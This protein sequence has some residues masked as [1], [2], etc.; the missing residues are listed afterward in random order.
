MYSSCSINWSNLL[1][2]NGSWKGLKEISWKRLKDVKVGSKRNKLTAKCLSKSKSLN[3]LRTSRSLT[4]FNWSLRAHWSVSQ[5]RRSLSHRGRERRC[6]SN[7][8][9][10]NTTTLARKETTSSSTDQTTI[11]QSKC[12]TLKMLNNSTTSH[13]STKVCRKRQSKPCQSRA[14]SILISKISTS[15]KGTQNV[16]KALRA[17]P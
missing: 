13:Q 8:W 1:P 11:I 6:R 9:I 16:K 2:G 4:N 10:M 3:K 17:C 7:K 5:W 15:L 12:W 14:H